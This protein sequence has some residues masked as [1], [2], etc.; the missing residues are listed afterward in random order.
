MNPPAYR[1]VLKLPDS[2]DPRKHA[3][4]LPEFVNKQLGPGWKI[5]YLD[6]RQAA[7]V[8]DR[9]VAVS[10]VVSETADVSYV[11]LAE[12]TKLGD[13]DRLAATFADQ[14][15]GYVMTRFEPHLGWAELT[16]MSEATQRARTAVATALRV[17]PWEVAIAERADGGYELG[18]PASFQRSKHGQKLEEVATDS[19]GEFGWYVSIDS[20]ALRASIIP[21]EAPTFPPK[22]DYPLTGRLD[23]G[24]YDTVI[25]LGMS[26][27]APGEEPEVFSLDFDDS[28]GQLGGLAGSGKSV[29]LNC[30]IAGALQRGF[31]LA[32]V[33]TPDKAVD[34][35]WCKEFVRPNGWGCD[36]REAAVAT[37][38]SLYDEARSRA[39]VFAKYQAKKLADLPA[40]VRKTMPPIMLIVD[41]LTGLFA[42]EAVPKSLPSDHPMRVEAEQYNVAVDITKNR[43][44]K[45][46]AE[47]RFVGL[48]SFLSSQVASRDTGADTK[49]RTNLHHKI[50]L[51]ARATEAN[52]KL[53]F[54]DPDAVPIVPE[55]IASDKAASRGVGSAQPEGGK[56][57]VFKTF[58]A[59]TDAM[60]AHLK[61]LGVPTHTGQ[62]PDD[63]LIA[64][65][66]PKLSGDDDADSESVAARK[67]MHKAAMTDP[68]TGEPLSG[69]EY[70]NR[71]R[72]A[73]VSK[74][75]A[76]SRAEQW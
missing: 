2:F 23:P 69:F 53:V 40:D 27:P 72:A 51:G 65:Y 70:A 4:Q 47:M 21:A 43:I 52:R 5:A 68:E 62:A 58:Y 45:I 44:N 34:F 37:V 54:P 55:H 32:I 41:E 36:S 29:L 25:P 17:K 60:H 73:S 22:F 59:D 50:L 67:A 24:G 31:E 49:L 64:R 57:V 9:E 39:R 71:Q 16:R 10:T 35:L 66:M 13:G 48:R 56:P 74:A 18:L 38:S 75:E 42:K 30:L 26:L 20:K 14:K 11:H 12:G 3:K 46:A 61:Q 19:I 7:V 6:P 33:D 8:V 63:E 28:N 15:P 76:D 1:Q